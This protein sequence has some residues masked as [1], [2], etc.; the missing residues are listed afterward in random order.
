MGATEPPEHAM[1]VTDR[2]PLTRPDPHR[3]RNRP[4]IGACAAIT[5]GA[6]TGT[7][8]LLTS[9]S[10]PGRQ[11]PPQPVASGTPSSEASATPTAEQ[12]AL[13]Q[14]EAR[15]T[16]FIKTTDRVAQGGYASIRLYDTV[17]INKARIQLL[18]TAT[19][20]A[21]QR[22]TGDTKIASLTVQSVSLP[23]DPRQTYPEVRLLSCL[24]VSGTDAFDA[25]GKSVVSPSRL[26][27]IR[28]DVLLQKIPPGV[29]T[30][31]R[32]RSGWFV[33]DVKQPGQP[34]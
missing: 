15:Y 5:V 19:R 17:A 32:T 7:A 2:S 25:N 22:V 23:A 11:T 9:S 31:D 26:T 20:F 16:A 27:R 30:T 33:S 1:S 10:K 28:S 21:G 6:L 13:Q 18:L 12:L 8:L 4:F 34:C 29:F 24:D 3:T 14:A